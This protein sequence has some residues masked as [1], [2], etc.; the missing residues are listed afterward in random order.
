MYSI[1]KTPSC[2]HKGKLGIPCPFCKKWIFNPKGTVVEDTA[3]LQWF[4]IY[5]NA[6]FLS[7]PP[8][9]EP[10]EDKESYK[11][12]IILK[13]LEVDN[14]V[15]IIFTSSKKPPVFNEEALRELLKE[16]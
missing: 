5:C 16:V 11:E 4:C 12:K 9:E 7:E 8:F 3:K 2:S 1:D 14:C 13:L 6:E 15:N 10:G